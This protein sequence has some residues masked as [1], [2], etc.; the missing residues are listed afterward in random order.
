MTE[1]Q[2]GSSGRFFAVISYL[3]ILCLVPLVFKRSDRFAVHHAKQGL[4][5]LVWE[6]AAGVV[7]ILPFVGQLILTLSWLA[8]SILSLIGIV[9][10]WAGVW[11][12]LPGVLGKWA[13]ELEV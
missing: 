5:L 11:W 4:I 3:S 1:P 10:A 6:V 13:E 8:C 2:V 7:S 12:R 9:Q